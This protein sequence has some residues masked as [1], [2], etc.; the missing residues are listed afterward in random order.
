[1]KWLKRETISGNIEDK[2]REHFGNKADKMIEEL[3]NQ[4]QFMAPDK[5]ITLCDNIMI[6]ENKGGLKTYYTRIIE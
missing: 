1:M 2:L 3:S 6:T 4:A 5:I